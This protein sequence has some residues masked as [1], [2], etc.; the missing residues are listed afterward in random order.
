MANLDLE[1][2]LKNKIIMTRKMRSIRNGVLAILIMLSI[3]AF[4]Q[5]SSETENEFNTWMELKLKKKI[6]RKFSFYVAPQ[7]RLTEVST[8]DKYLLETGVKYKLN[9]NMSIGALYRFTGDQKSDH[10]DYYHRYGLDF[11]AYDKF[12]RFE[13]EVRLRYS[14]ITDFNDDSSEKYMRYKGL[15]VYD[16][17]K[18]K[19]TP[20]ISAEAFQQPS[21]DGFKKIR[22][23]VGGEFKL[24]NGNYI[25]MSYRIDYYLDKFKNSHILG[26][27][28]KIKL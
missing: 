9:K 13:P 2:T 21:T 7:L 16:I 3:Q 5:E 14:N 23:G 22:Y 20:F 11:K 17:P 15:V 6:N 18:C 28:Y 1:L 19:F 12:G 4:A 26:L 24:P 25:G 10:T 8:L 27:N